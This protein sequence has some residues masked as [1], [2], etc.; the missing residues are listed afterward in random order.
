MTD[1]PFKVTKDNCLFNGEDPFMV[2]D[3]G[4][5]VFTQDDWDQYQRGEVSERIKSLWQLNI[6]ELT[7]MVNAGV[8]T[9][10]SK[11]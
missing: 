6:K 5:L 9:L 11:E 8:Y 2:K 10:I 3:S 1:K 7:E 4:T